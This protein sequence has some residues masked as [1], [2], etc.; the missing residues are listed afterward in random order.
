MP[1][2]EQFQKLM[3]MTAVSMQVIEDFCGTALTSSSLG[4]IE[5]A[6]FDWGTITLRRR[7][8]SSKTTYHLVVQD[9]AGAIR[10]DRDV[11]AAVIAAAIRFNIS[12]IASAL[13]EDEQALAFVLKNFSPNMLWP[14]LEK[15]RLNVATGK[16]LKKG[17]GP[18]RV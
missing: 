9:S 10:D 15:A 12:P 5:I 8:E 11:E 1:K 14:I 2:I 7:V 6:R 4:V 16:A 18:L 17:A 13:L 3:G